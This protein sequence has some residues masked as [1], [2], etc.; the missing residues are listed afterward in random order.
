MPT[1]NDNYY[2]NMGSTTLK[3]EDTDQINVGLT[4]Q[5]SAGF[6]KALVITADGY[7]N[8]VKNKIVAIPKNMFMWSMTNLG[9]VRAFGTDV[10]LNATFAL[11]N[12]NSL[13]LASNYSFQRVQPRTS[14]ADLDY[15]K[16]VAYT[17]VHSGA[18]SLSWQNPWADL[19]VH[20]TGVS[21]RYGTNAN[22]PVTR[23]DGYIE[24]G[25]AVMK[26][27]PLGKH[28]L[29]LRFDLVNLFDKQ[30]EVVASYPMPGRSW[31]FTATFDL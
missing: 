31:K 17:P 16:Q 29:A 9:K 3:P 13:V 14:K 1:F 30:Y 11:N 18:A 24:C 27:F 2:F 8:H 23:L 12:A 25:A 15:N 26:T 4:W 28:S 5:T 19:V 7:Y 20:A 22:L 21:E 10:T 6:M